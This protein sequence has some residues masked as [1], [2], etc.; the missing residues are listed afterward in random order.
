MSNRDAGIN[1]DG[2]I[3]GQGIPWEQHV[4][5][6]LSPD[7]LYVPDSKVVDHFNPTTG[8]VINSK[9][10]NTALPGY[11]FYPENIFN[12][13][14]KYISAFAKYVP[15]TNLRGWDVPPEKIQSRQIMLAVPEKTSPEQWAQI[16]RAQEFAENN[17]V[18][19]NVTRIR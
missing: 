9:T 8:D 13:L 17:G 5:S 6:Q 2:G 4:A 12:T 10:L 19:L 14:S 15:G 3:E 7:Y 1:W 11:T 18:K 16:V